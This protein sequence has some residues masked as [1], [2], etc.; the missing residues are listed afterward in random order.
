MNICAMCI[1]EMNSA[2]RSGGV[3]RLAGPHSFVSENNTYITNS[4]PTGSV[5]DGGSISTDVVMTG[6]VIKDN[7]ANSGTIEVGNLKTFYINYTEF[8]NNTS[9]G[10]TIYITNSVKHFKCINCKFWENVISKVDQVILDQLHVKNNN[11]T[12]GSMIM[13][14]KSI[15]TTVVSS[16]FQDNL[17]SKL[18]CAVSVQ[19]SDN[20]KIKN[21]SFVNDM[22]VAYTISQSKDNQGAVD[23]DASNIALENVHFKGIPGYVYKAVTEEKLFFRNVSYE[24]LIHI[25]RY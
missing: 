2:L 1:Y 6:D 15:N 10:P 17:C 7:T 19:E 11:V 9:E 3:F 12:I 5:L 18:P 22:S 25:P 14:K 8:M 23:L 4:A 16:F 21:F 20:V 24:C 13:I